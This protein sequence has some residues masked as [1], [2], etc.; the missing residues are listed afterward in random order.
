MFPCRF[1]RVVVRGISIDEA[2]DEEAVKRE[3]PV[4]WR[5]VIGMVATDI[6][7][8]LPVTFGYE[9]SVLPFAPVIQYCSSSLVLIQVVLDLKG[10]ISEGLRRR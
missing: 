7:A 4:V 1:V 10:I 6:L 8:V 3:A 9:F 5:L 2:V